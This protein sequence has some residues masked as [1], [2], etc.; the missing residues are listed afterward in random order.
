[1]L[2]NAVV[3]MTV[4][5]AWTA[6]SLYIV[7][8]IAWAT[9]MPVRRGSTFEDLFEYPFVLLWPGPALGIAGAWMALKF[10]KRAL[11]LTCVGLPLGLMCLIVAWYYMAPVAYL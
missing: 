11:A 10:G 4:L 8:P 1:M 3:A 9:W 5:F 6:V 2:V 7:E